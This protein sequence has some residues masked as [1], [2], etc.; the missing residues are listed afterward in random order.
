VL[1]RHNGFWNISD[2]FESSESHTYQ[3]VWQGDY[4]TNSSTTIEKEYNDKT[5]LIIQQ[6]NEDD[7]KI[8]SGQIRNK[9]NAVISVVKKGNYSFITLVKPIRNDKNSGEQSLSSCLNGEQWL[10]QEKMPNMNT[11]AS[12][13]LTA[14]NTTVLVNCTNFSYGDI[15]IEIDIPATLVLEIEN[16][17]GELLYLG[18]KRANILKLT[19]LKMKSGNTDDVLYP[20]ERIR[21]R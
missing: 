1:F 13:I 14:Y 7:Y 12:V 5:G 17:G 10:I 18:R 16:E 11:D 20:G 8:D 19:K 3:Q 6:L 4:K 21:F 9:H 15:S 2:H